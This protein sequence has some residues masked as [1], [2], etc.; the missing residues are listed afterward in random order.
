[1]EA[2]HIIPYDEINDLSV[3]I[4]GYSYSTDSLPPLVHTGVK[5]QI[6]D[7]LESIRM[8][9]FPKCIQRYPQTLYVFPGRSEQERYWCIQMFGLK[10]VRYILLKLDISD[11]VQWFKESP[12]R[13]LFKDIDQRCE[14]YW[15]SSSSI[16]SLEDTDIEGLYK[17]QIKVLERIEKKW[18]GFNRKCIP[19]EM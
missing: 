1:M 9:D 19:Y 12:L 10:Y 6:E 14:E 5:K 4:Q 18:D 8:H 17:G 15:N 3:Y 2:W 16:T 13:N 7:S 11:D